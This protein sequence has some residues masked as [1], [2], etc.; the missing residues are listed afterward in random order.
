[1]KEK[2]KVGTYVIVK[3]VDLKGAF[4]LFDKIRLKDY[5]GE[6]GIVVEIL[7]PNLF[8]VKFEPIPDGS[9]KQQKFSSEDIDI[10]I[11]RTREERLKKLLDE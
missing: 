8:L 10:D 2:I 7:E 4:N 11:I 1:M 5:M 6:K 3:E 9:Y